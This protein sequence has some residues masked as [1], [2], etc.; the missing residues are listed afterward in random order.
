MLSF[1]ELQPGIFFVLEIRYI[2]HSSNSQKVSFRL[3]TLYVY[4]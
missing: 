3:K 1:L 4:I 2:L